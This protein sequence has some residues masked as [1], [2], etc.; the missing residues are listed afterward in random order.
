MSD[1]GGGGV[2]QMAPGPGLEGPLCDEGRVGGG[3]QGGVVERG[4]GSGSGVR[5]EAQGCVFRL[6]QGAP[7]PTHTRPD[8][9]PSA[10]ATGG[11]GSPT[12]GV[13]ARTA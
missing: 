13:R 5:T 1:S 6:K 2:E 12:M 4:W 11:Q 7:P 10:P 3:V 8:A 9:K